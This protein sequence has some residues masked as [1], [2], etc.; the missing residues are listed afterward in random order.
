MVSLKGRK[1][2]LDANTIIYAVE[3]PQFSNLKTGL[4]IPLDAQ[5]FTAVTS[6]ITLAETVIG[7]R[8]AGNMA[9]EQLFRKFLTPSSNFLLE[10]ITLAVLE[11]VID[12]RAQYSLKIP[13]A[14]HLAT[15]ILAGCDLFVTGDH[16]WS[17]AGVTVV[18]PADV[19]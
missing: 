19:G 18:D 9:T 3:L 2:Y 8:K 17:K 12:L 15:G 13:D 10:P 4:L 1:V 5:E 11:K 16:V 6:E 7:P 14:I